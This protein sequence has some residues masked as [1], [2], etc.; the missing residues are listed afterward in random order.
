[1]VLGIAFGFQQN[2][3]AKIDGRVEAYQNSVYPKLN[4]I[5]VNLASMSKDI[6]W[7][8]KTLGEAEVK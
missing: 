1:M 7:I 8:K 5:N 4:D 6:D 2:Q 3:I